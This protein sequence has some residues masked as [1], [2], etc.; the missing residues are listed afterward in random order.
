MIYFSDYIDLYNT[1]NY[2]LAIDLMKKYSDP[3]VICYKQL[4]LLAMCYYDLIIDLDNDSINEQPQMLINIQRG[5]SVDYLSHAQTFPIVNNL[6]SA[7]NIKRYDTIGKIIYAL[8]HLQMNPINPSEMFP[9]ILSD[10]FD[11]ESPSVSKGIT[12]LEES[13][14]TNENESQHIFYI[15]AKIYLNFDSFSIQ[16]EKGNNYLIRSARLNHYLAIKELNSVG[17]NWKD[18]DQFGDHCSTWV[19]IPE[20]NKNDKIRSCI[21]CGKENDGSGWTHCNF[22]ICGIKTELNSKEISKY[23][24][25]G[26]MNTL[27]SFEHI[28]KLLGCLSAI[29][30]VG[31]ENLDTDKVYIAQYMTVIFSTISLFIKQE[32]KEFEDQ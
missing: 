19:C 6:K 12:I 28:I 22:C 8:Y 29:S 14:K 4:Y 17:V 30:A 9:N 32:I 3:S 5:L 26:F 13:L 23:C 18:I 25:S 2:N 16:K 24:V 27:K 11:N 7:Y 15:L 20:F 1:G 10:L 21:G 31:L